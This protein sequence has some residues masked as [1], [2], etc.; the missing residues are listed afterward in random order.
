MLFTRRSAGSWLG[1]EKGSYRALI[2]E[3]RCRPFSGHN[4]R[5]VRPTSRPGTAS[6]RADKP[7]E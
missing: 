7:R 4:R 5:P 2:G 1:W 6:D 3:I